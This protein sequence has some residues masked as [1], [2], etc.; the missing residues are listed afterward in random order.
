M[1][2]PSLK[3]GD[4]TTAKIDGGKIS[5]N[6]DQIKFGDFYEIFDDFSSKVI[7]S[8]L[9]EDRTQI[10]TKVLDRLNE[11]IDIKISIPEN[12]VPAIPKVVYV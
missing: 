11:P 5:V 7:G 6:F 2:G 9:F 12:I 3:I 1:V 10:D 4:I 8:D